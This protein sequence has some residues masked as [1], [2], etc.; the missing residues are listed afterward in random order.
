MSC[1]TS[2]FV[3]ISSIS[4]YAASAWTQVQSPYTYIPVTISRQP[5]CVKLQ[6][7]TTVQSKASRFCTGFCT[8]SQHIPLSP[9]SIPFSLPKPGF[10]FLMYFSLSGSVTMLQVIP[11]KTPHKPSMLSRKY[12]HIVR[13][14]RQDLIYQIVAW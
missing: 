2:L 14:N 7:I 13:G 4:P 11:V 10:P 5:L 3:A 8:Q 6:I 12:Q 9:S 1:G